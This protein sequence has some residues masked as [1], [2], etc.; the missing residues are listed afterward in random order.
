MAAV[1]DEQLVRYSAL[2]VVF[3]FLEKPAGV[4]VLDVRCDSLYIV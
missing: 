3:V 2:Y 1:R 4:F